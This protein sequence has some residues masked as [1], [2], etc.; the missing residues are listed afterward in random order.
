MPGGGLTLLACLP[1]DVPT[2]ASGKATIFFNLTS[3]LPSYKNDVGTVLPLGATGAQG[4]I[5]PPMVVLDEYI[6]TNLLAGPSGSG[7]SS[8]LVLLSSQVASASAALN[9][10]TQLT[11]LYDDYLFEFVSIVPVT[12]A[13]GFIGEISTDGGSTWQVTAYARALSLTT[14][15]NV[16]VATGAT[17]LTKLDFAGTLSNSSLGSLS[18]T[19]YM[20]DPLN[21]A[22]AKAFEGHLSFLHSDTNRNHFEGTWWWVS[23][24]A[25]NA[26]RFRMD[27]GN[28]ASGTIRLYGISKT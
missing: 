2:P 12:N 11:S 27:S 19:M 3:G 24:T 8:G 26:V 23:A 28:I 5:G 9:F 16:H 18:G 1:A 4:P 14:T 7:G 13:V 22:A 15:A 17:G 6:E 10:T 20:R 25:V 21:A